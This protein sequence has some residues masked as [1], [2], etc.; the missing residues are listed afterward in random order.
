M[1][2]DKRRSEEGDDSSGAR[3]VSEEEFEDDPLAYINQDEAVVIVG[4]QGEPVAYF[5]IQHDMNK[6]FDR[7]EIQVSK[8]D[9]KEAR[10]TGNPWID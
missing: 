5:G 6:K 8:T 3:R 10:E 4:K 7:P 1:M 2:E 9:I